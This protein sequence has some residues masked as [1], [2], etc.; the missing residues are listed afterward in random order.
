MMSSADI[1]PFDHQFVLGKSPYFLHDLEDVLSYEEENDFGSHNENFLDYEVNDVEGSTSLLSVDPPDET[2]KKKVKLKEF[3]ASLEHGQDSLP[4]SSNMYSSSSV[5]QPDILKSVKRKQPSKAS[6]V[7]RKKTE[8]QPK[9]KAHSKRK[10]KK[11]KTVSERQNDDKVK[12]NNSKVK[13]SNLSEK[14]CQKPMVLTEETDLILEHN[15]S[16]QAS[17]LKKP[18][19]IQSVPAASADLSVSVVTTCAPSTTSVLLAMMGEAVSAPKYTSSASDSVSPFDIPSCPT[20][21]SWPMLREL[22]SSPTQ[23]TVSISRAPRQTLST[24]H[25]EPLA[26]EEPAPSV[27]SKLE[28]EIKCVCK[29][30]KGKP[31]WL[32]F[33]EERL[34]KER[35]HHLKLKRESLDLVILAKI[36]ANINREEKVK[37]SQK[38][39]R[40]RCR[41]CYYHESKK[42]C[43]E[44]FLFIHG[45]CKGRLCALM[46]HYKQ[47]GISA[48][49]H[50]NKANIPHHALSNDDSERVLDFIKEYA[51]KHCVSPFGHTSG[52]KTSRGL[53]VMSPSQ[54]K[55][56][57]HHKYKL[58]CA[59]NSLRAVSLRSFQN[60]WGKHLPYIVVLRGSNKVPVPEPGSE[61]AIQELNENSIADSSDPL[62]SSCEPAVL[63]DSAT[64]AA[65]TSSD[66]VID[67]SNILKI[68]SISTYSTDNK[69]N[70]TDSTDS[71]DEIFYNSKKN[72]KRK[73]FPPRKID[74]FESF[75]LA[76]MSTQDL[77]SHQLFD[78]RHI[79]MQSDSDV[80]PGLNDRADDD[81]NHTLDAKA[82]SHQ[83]EKEGV[84]QQHSAFSS[85]PLIPTC[86]TA[87]ATTQVLHHPSEVAMGFHS[88][89]SNPV[90]LASNRDVLCAYVSKSPVHVD[91][92][93]TSSIHPAFYIQQNPQLFDTFSMQGADRLGV[94]LA[95]PN[96]LSDPSQTVLLPSHQTSELHDVHPLDWQTWQSF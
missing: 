4:V 11:T 79:P 38:R 40:Q 58:W 45:I 29:F 65:E 70:D 50:G 51:N 59:K 78:T 72:N 30:N 19:A 27:V 90:M 95:T 13:Q 87:A 24:V 9:K 89:S 49:V 12:A 26:V 47:E 96:G 8:S 16:Q 85:D 63:G 37:K 53:V 68:P 21:S 48:R 71:G 44:T 74:S 39:E 82:S 34:R 84:F 60:L 20:R 2:T 73:A 1:L 46:K 33:D 3:Q 56:Y 36:A 22:I 81:M 28:K 15:R 62:P 88:C 91:V 41:L 31:C 7:R 14:S 17:G 54:S 86:T 23:A 10:G 64:L 18:L 83:S 55:L 52:S 77:S 94:T 75:Q 67:D 61:A 32:L 66:S 80:A 25:M 69:K 35:L 42:I 93:K 57:V 92:V 43:R 5:R 76:P 6:C